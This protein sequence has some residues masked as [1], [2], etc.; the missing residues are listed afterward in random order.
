MVAVIERV[1]SFLSGGRSSEVQTPPSLVAKPIQTRLEPYIDRDP[2][3]P[4][5]RRGI[6]ELASLISFRK[7]RSKEVTG[8]L[9]LE[10][11]L[12]SSDVGGIKPL[13]RLYPYIDFPIYAF[14]L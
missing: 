1:R 10:F 14:L 9:S 5:L 4:I 11:P 2:R 7:F 8:E 13:R 12:L 6:E 3:N